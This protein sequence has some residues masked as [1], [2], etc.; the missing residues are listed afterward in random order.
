MSTLL[1]LSV[2]NT[3]WID[4]TSDYVQ[5]VYTFAGGSFVDIRVNLYVTGIRISLNAGSRLISL[6]EIEVFEGDVS[7]KGRYAFSASYI[8]IYEDKITLMIDIFNGRKT[9]IKCFC[10]KA[11]IV[12][13]YFC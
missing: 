7:Y 6:N 10:Q 12:S 5:T 4:V 8:S 9:L 13:L 3:T 2:F 11:L 1:Q